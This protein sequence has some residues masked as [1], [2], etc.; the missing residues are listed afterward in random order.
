[1]F[2]GR[3]IVMKRLIFII[4]LLFSFNV[5]ATTFVCNTDKATYILVNQLKLI[6]FLALNQAAL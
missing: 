1:M 4:V 5:M 3:V 2:D 6:Q